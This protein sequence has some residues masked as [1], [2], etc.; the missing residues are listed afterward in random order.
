MR[1]G[2]GLAVV[3]FAFVLVLSFYGV[4]S[5]TPT[6]FVWGV[7]DFPVASLSY[8]SKYGMMPVLYNVSPGAFPLLTGSYS[9][10]G[11]HTFPVFKGAKS[12]FPAPGSFNGYIGLGLSSSKAVN[13][14]IY[15]QWDL[16]STLGEGAP[17]FTFYNVTR[18]YTVVPCPEGLPPELMKGFLDA[19][20][21]PSP[22]LSMTI[23]DSFIVSVENNGTVDAVATVSPFVVGFQITI[24]PT[25]L[26][27]WAFLIF[28]AFFTTLTLLSEIVP[29]VTRED[30]YERNILRSGFKLALR[31]PLQ[32]VLP[33]TLLIIP[34]PYLLLYILEAVSRFSAY[35]APFITFFAIVDIRQI[36]AFVP[37][38]LAAAVVL[39]MFLIAHIVV[40]S[41]VGV[42]RSQAE[43]VKEQEPLS[44]GVNPYILVGGLLLVLGLYLDYVFFTHLTEIYMQL[45]LYTL[46]NIAWVLAILIPIVVFIISIIYTLR[47]VSASADRDERSSGEIVSEM[48][49][50]YSRLLGLML[51]DFFI[52]LPVGLVLGV[53]GVYLLNPLSYPLTLL[54]SPV[55]EK[56]FTT[57][58]LSGSIIFG[59]LVSFFFT[60]PL[61]LNTL[62][63]FRLKTI[64]RYEEREEKKEP[65]SWFEA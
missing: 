54:Y 63:Y 2:S 58:M 59:V 21:F 1:T 11:F 14:S 34:A 24:N 25:Y 9:L 3:F 33:Y 41:R 55:V 62:L 56:S 50:P 57:L 23:T 52:I 5:T 30:V 13:V 38:A 64:S 39:P 32:T 31:E 40:Y 20:V 42:I 65:P 17:L 53:L 51:L 49:R 44:A 22:L 18:L 46:G 27:S 10:G 37:I 28:S 15:S 45:D 29:N 16:I 4:S 48:R 60:L 8:H 19:Q 36:G 6:N 7:M 47:V 26:F 12:V 43:G 61:I 35:W